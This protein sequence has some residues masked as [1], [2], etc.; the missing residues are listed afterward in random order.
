MRTVAGAIVGA[1][2]GGDVVK[3]VIFSTDLPFRIYLRGLLL[4]NNG[5]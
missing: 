2:S 1:A 5:S 3:D 4:N